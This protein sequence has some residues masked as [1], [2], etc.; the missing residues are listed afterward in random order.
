M[1]VSAAAVSLMRRRDQERAQRVL[2][3]GAVP[4][5]VV[6]DRSEDRGG[7]VDQRV[8]LVQRHQHAMGADMI[9][10][11]HRRSAPAPL[12]NAPRFARL[13]QAPAQLAVVGRDA[14]HP[15]DGAP[16]GPVAGERVGELLA[17]RGDLVGTGGP[18]DDRHRVVAA[19]RHDGRNAAA[20]EGAGQQLGETGHGRRVL[21]G[22]CHRQRRERPVG[23]DRERAQPPRQLAAAARGVV[24]DLQQLARE[25]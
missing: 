11:G 5:V 24:E 16:V 14:A 15:D 23:V 20:D 22:K 8:F 4:G 18:A 21:V 25:A 2:E 19:L 13:E 3:V 7:E 1:H 10:R 12:R 9:K 17:Q 6:A